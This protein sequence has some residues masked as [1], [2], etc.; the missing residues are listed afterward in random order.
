MLPGRSL[1][2]LR[3][4]DLR[5]LTLLATEAT[6]AVSAPSALGQHAEAARQLLFAPDHPYIACRTSH[7]QLLG[8]PVV[9]AQLLRWL[10]P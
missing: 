9:T 8:S 2:P 6:H 1:H 10:K 5:A 4:S 7:L 3:A